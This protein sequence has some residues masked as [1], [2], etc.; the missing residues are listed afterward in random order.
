M[1]PRRH[2]QVRE[3]IEQQGELDMP[4]LGQVEEEASAEESQQQQQ[5]SSSSSSGTS[6]SHS[7]T[8][9]G[10]PWLSSS[11]GPYT[12]KRGSLGWQQREVSLQYLPQ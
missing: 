4:V 5:V 10:S 9:I 2:R 8:Q 3:L 12:K 1:A 7:S 6:P 11:S